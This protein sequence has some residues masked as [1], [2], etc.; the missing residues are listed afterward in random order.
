MQCFKWVKL[1]KR[2]YKWTDISNCI[3]YVTCNG[4][5]IHRD[6]DIVSD[7]NVLDSFNFKWLKYGLINYFFI[8]KYYPS[9][10]TW[11]NIVSCRTKCYKPIIIVTCDKAW[12]FHSRSYC[13]H[14]LVLLSNYIRNG[15]IKVEF[16]WVFQVDIDFVQ[17]ITIPTNRSL[18]GSAA[19]DKWNTEVS[20]EFN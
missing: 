14:I 2:T 18:L 16:E 15:T 20:F 11:N 12:K 1:H 9:M 6:C 7:F 13:I 8:D 5:V 4:I 3:L 10:V 17:I 19:S